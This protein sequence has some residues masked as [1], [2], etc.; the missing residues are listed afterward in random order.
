MNKNFLFF[1]KPI[2]WKAVRNFFY[3]LAASPE[4]YVMLLAAGILECKKFEGLN[5]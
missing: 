2:I 1:Q 3:I 4:S 5:L